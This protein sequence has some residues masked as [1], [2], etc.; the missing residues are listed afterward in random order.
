[1]KWWND[2]SAVQLSGNVCVCVFVPR[3]NHRK[4]NKTTVMNNRNERKKE[5]LSSQ[6]PNSKS[7]KMKT[8]VRNVKR[9]ENEINKK[10]NRISQKDRK[11]KIENGNEN[12]RMK[13]HSETHYEHYTHL[14]W[15]IL[16]CVMLSLDLQLYSHIL[17]RLA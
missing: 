13:V 16:K 9:N 2:E 14:V 15:T 4:P 5:T 12:N 7:Y 8:H 17:V 6:T 10:K 3:E 1:M 11:R